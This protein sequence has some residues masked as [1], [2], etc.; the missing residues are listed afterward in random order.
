MKNSTIGRRLLTG[1]GLVVTI[2]AAMGLFGTI[3][4]ATVQGLAERITND[5]LPGVFLFGEIQGMARENLGLTIE[6]IS[7]DDPIRRQAIQQR[8]SEVSTS[9]NR[10]F[11]D[12][13][14]MIVEPRDRELFV[15][16][17][18]G[19]DEIREARKPLFEFAKTHPVKESLALFD[20][21]VKPVFDS[22]M[23][24]IRAEILYNQRKGG[25]LS[26]EITSTV[27]S[28]REWMGIAV[29]LAI[30]ACAGIAFVVVRR[31]NRVLLTSVEE[32]T[33]GSGQVV[34]A[35]GQV[36]TSAQSLSQGATEQAASL[37]EASASMEEMASMTRKNAENATEAAALVADV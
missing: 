5:A 4:L 11:D 19:R 24:A 23:K 16:A 3:R 1:F 22:Y 21:T 26:A 31:A 17:K 30:A 14:R 2:T 10:L 37:Q 25:Q 20:S 28:S 27:S 36:A 34:S 33:D 12:Y 32:L 15:E 13:E 35:A 29:L 8:M 9:N 7:T 18:R 6:Y